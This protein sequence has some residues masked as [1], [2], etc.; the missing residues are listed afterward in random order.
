MAAIEHLWGLTPFNYGI[1]AGIPKMENSVSEVAT[2]VGLFFCFFVN[3]S[4]D[5]LRIC[6]F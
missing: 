5:I 6:E 2:A 4:N 3:I 1:I